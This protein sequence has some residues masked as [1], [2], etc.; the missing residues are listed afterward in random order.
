MLKKAIDPD[1][2]T[3]SMLGLAIGDA[4]GAAVEFQVKGSFPEVT[5]YRGGGPHGIPA[6]S[7]TDD[8]SMA[9]ALADSI[10]SEGWDLSDQMERFIQ[11][12]EAGKYSSTGFC[13]D[14]GGT[15]SAAIENFKQN[16]NPH[17]CGGTSANSSGNGAVMR[18]APLAIAFGWIDDVD[19]YL[20]LSEMSSALT[21]ANLESR[22]CSRAFAVI[23]RRAMYFNCSSP[24][25]VIR[26]NSS[27]MPKI[28]APK[29]RNEFKKEVNQIRN[30]DFDWGG[31][32]LWDN[33]LE[34]LLLLIGGNLNIES[35][36]GNVW[37]SGH[38]PKSLL[39]AFWAFTSTDNFRDCVLAAVNLGQD[40]D[41][42]GAI[43]GQIAG[44][45]Y[46]LSGIPTDL[47]AG[48]RNKDMLKQY[49]SPIV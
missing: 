13:F 4:L 27:M 28:T 31:R 38:V 39:A 42:T 6:G 43:A 23:L 40:A 11:W 36:E 1:K 3:G 21:H 49:L 26:R 37:G 32:Y 22:I 34:S 47:I 33:S 12:K 20:N 10:G 14:I 9:L 46:G 2:Q 18:Q 45:F 44:A 41:T 24:V 48:L 5:G 25:E 7:F 19:H 17:T 30:R 8:T 15:C 35:L 29:K 16:R